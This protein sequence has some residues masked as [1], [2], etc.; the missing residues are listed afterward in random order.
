MVAT[1]RHEGLL[2]ALFGSSQGGGTE[3]DG[4]DQVGADF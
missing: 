1:K 3:Y 4:R 2:A